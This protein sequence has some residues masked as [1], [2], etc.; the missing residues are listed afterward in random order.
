MTSYPV[1]VR[2]DLGNSFASMLRRDNWFQIRAKNQARE[3]NRARRWLEYATGVQRRAMYDM[4]A[5][6]MRATKEGDHDFAAFGHCV[7]TDELNKDR[8]GLLYRTWHPRDVAWVDGL[9]GKPETIFRKWNPS[10]RTLSRYF[11]GRIHRNV[12]R[13]A[14]KDPYCEIECLHVQYPAED[15]EGRWRTP[16]VSIYVDVE[17]N[18]IIEEVPSHNSY[19]IPRWQTISGSQYAFSPATITALPDARLIQKMALTLLEAGE[20]AANPPVVA[21]NNLFR[22]DFNYFAGGLTF[23]D[24][25]SNEK[26]QDALQV[27]THDKSGIPLS[28]DMQRDLRA[29]MMECF[30]LNKLNLPPPEKEM[31]AYEASLRVKEYIRQ[32]MPIF[33]PMEYEYN[34]ALCEQTFDLL[35]RNGAF[36][37]IEDIPAS[38]RGQDVE[39]RFES[40]LHDAEDEEMPYRLQT[41]ANILALA[42]QLDPAAQYNFDAVT[43][44]R[45][46]LNAVAPA[47]WV[48]PEKELAQ[49]VE[50]YRNQQSV[51]N[52]GEVIAGGAQA[53]QEVGKASQALS[54]PAQ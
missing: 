17:N 40:P 53:A 19:I 54:E 16:F 29:L 52:M 28:G 37:P 41:S 23:A 36:G 45:D 13:Q 49:Q 3:D 48:V 38:L 32:A 42:A 1:I 47:T 35:M 24:L 20:R 25:D 8:N 15:Y 43:A 50:Q 2:R 6:F 34:G 12:S 46:A 11:P 31:T 51:Q 10:A 5:Q 44:L 39:F 33:E 18:H 4:S 14:E 7:I 21:K 9:D 22:E 26:I 30:Y 27:I